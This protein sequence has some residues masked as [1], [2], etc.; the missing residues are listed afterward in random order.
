MGVQRRLNAARVAP[1][2]GAKSDRLRDFRALVGLVQAGVDRT[3]LAAQ[4][5][6]ADRLA[7]ERRHGQHLLGR[8]TEEQLVG[9]QHIGLGNRPQVEG[10]AAF[11]AELAD[12]VVADALENMLA[13]RRPEYGA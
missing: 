11:L 10:D 9:R 13:L 2:P 3:R 8:G 6:M 1:W 12:Q 4:R 5:A 7:V